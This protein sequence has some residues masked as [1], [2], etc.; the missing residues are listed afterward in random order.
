MNQL[1]LFFL[2]LLATFAQF[3]LLILA[4]FAQVL[5]LGSSTFAQ[6]LLLVCVTFSQFLFLILPHFLE[7]SG[8]E[9]QNFPRIIKYPESSRTGEGG[10]V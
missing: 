2:L 5:F 8:N 7:E 9:A 3:L 10:K 4:T 6:F 1:V